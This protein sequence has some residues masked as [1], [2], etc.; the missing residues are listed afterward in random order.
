MSANNSDHKSHEG[1]VSNS[2]KEKIS[3]ER[4]REFCGA[5]GADVAS[6]APP[7]FLTVFRA[8]EFEL[9]ER[10]GIALASVLHG[11]QTYLYNSDLRAGDE[12]SFKTTLTSVH[13][14]KGARGQMTFLS[15]E[16]LIEAAGARTRR[17]GTSRTTIIVREA[18]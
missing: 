12:V 13:E 2:Y 18:T 16:T 4:I 14:K 11:E 6:T 5:V 9:L 3:D 8:G 17:V 1:A 7:T 15:F 10:M